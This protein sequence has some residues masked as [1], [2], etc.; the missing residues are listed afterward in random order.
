LIHFYKRSTMRNGNSLSTPDA[1]LQATYKVNLKNDP[2]VDQELQNFLDNHQYSENGILRYEKIF[3]ETFVSTGGKATTSK[4]LDQM[5]LK[6]GMNV[7]DI[8][9][10]IGGS[11]FLMAER[12]GVNVYGIDLSTNMLAIADRYRRKMDA[13]VKYRVQFHMDDA[14]KMDYPKEFFDVVY[15][16]D[17]IMHIEDKLSLYKKVYSC[18]KPGGTILI[19]EYATGDKEL[20]KDFLDYVADRDYQLVTVKEYGNVLEKAGFANVVA[21]DVTNF[22]MEMMVAELDKFEKMKDEFIAEFSEKDFTDIK[23]GWLVKMERCKRGDQVWGL[24]TA[25]KPL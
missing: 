7:M 18:L 25:Q 9:C 14:T 1:K 17:A 5:N 10:G 23:E 15:S 24:F 16:R 6:P 8:G 12:F 19:S 4:F 3:G 13:E 11:A 20:S 22:M 2:Q 21:E